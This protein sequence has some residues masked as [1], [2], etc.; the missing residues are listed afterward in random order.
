MPVVGIQHSSRRT[1][2]DAP[3]IGTATNVGSNRAFNNGRV[4]VTF[5]APAFNG[6]LEITGYTATAVEDP[7]KTV[8]GASSPLSVTGLLSATAYTFTVSATNAVG[9]GVGSTASSPV[10]VTT[11]PQTPNAPTVSIPVGQAFAAN[12]NVSVSVTALS[13]GGLPITAYNALSSSTATQ[14]GAANPLIF[15]EVRGT[16]RTYTGT[17][18]NNNGTSVASVA[19]ASITPS[20]I[21]DA[22]ATPSASAGINNATIT[23]AAPNDG[24]SA[25]TSY[26]MNNTLGGTRTNVTPPYVWTSLT[27]G[28]PLQFG[29]RAN[30]VNGT[31]N[32]SPNSNSVT[33]TAP[34]PPPIISIIAA[35]PIISIIAAPPK[36][37]PF[38][39][40][41]GDTLVS[42]NGG[43]IKARDIV[44]GNILKSYSFDELPESEKTY[45]VADWTSSLISNIA[46]QTAVVTN[47]QKIIKPVTMIFNRD[48]G[49]RFSLEHEMLIKRENKYIF[50]QSGT[51][52]IGDYL[53]SD[54]NNTNNDLLVTDIE[55][56]NEETDVY[57]IT[58]DKY[59][60]V[61]A[62]GLITHNIK[63]GYQGITARDRQLLPA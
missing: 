42:L 45:K 24:S 34:P 22:P 10:T 28:T 47:I 17:L 5:S 25:I 38:G 44:K 15:S 27:A 57:K 50:V 46:E 7:T 4:D 51:V 6:G 19:S 26:D 8:S 3:L 20:T 11:V 53:V 23:W 59:N 32:Y 12:A 36:P 2:P 9:T 37:P 30:N 33:P 58:L 56:I 62:G 39:C 55:F 35:P 29:V 21:P 54:K 43:F 48:Q 61:I 49:T 1:V 52:Q 60:L 41:Q 16:T 14:T 63:G 13:N 18:T 40:V 31:G